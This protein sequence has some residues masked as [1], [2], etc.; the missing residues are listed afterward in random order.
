MIPTHFEN[1]EKC[2]GRKILANFH[3]IPTQYENIRKF[4]EVHKITCLFHRSVVNLID[5]GSSAIEP[6]SIV[7][8]LRTGA[9]IVYEH[10]KI[11]ESNIKRNEMLLQ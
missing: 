6:P 10:E 11:D 3:T 7:I 2:D 8:V 9:T 4:D 5:N 1:D